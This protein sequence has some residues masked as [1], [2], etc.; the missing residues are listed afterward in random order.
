M[1]GTSCDRCSF[2]PYSCERISVES[3]LLPAVTEVVPAM[4][5]GAPQLYEDAPGN[6]CGDWVV[7]D[8]AATDA[9]FS[10]APHIAKIDLVNNRLVPQRNRGLPWR[11]TSPRPATT[12]SIPRPSFPM[13][14]GY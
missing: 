3:R 13:S 14:R 5:R 6:L 10:K 7:G 1:Y 4:T 2:T 12:R 9:A 11:S 8:A